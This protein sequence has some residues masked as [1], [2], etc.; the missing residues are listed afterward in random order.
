MNKSLCA[1]IFLVLLVWSPLCFGLK[2]V[3]AKK[4]KTKLPNDPTVWCSTCISFMVQ[5]INQLLNIIANIGVLGSCAELCGYLPNKL[6][7]AVCNVL[8]DVVGIEGFIDL[9]EIA[10]PD[11]VWLC[12]ELDMCT[13]RDSARAKIL[14][15]GVVPKSAPQ[16]TTFNL[17]VKYQV[18]NLTGT[19][20]VGFDV[21]DP[22][23]FIFGDGI[24]IE[25]QTPG[26]YGYQ[27]QLDTDPTEDEPFFPGR[28][29]VTIAVCEGTCG[30]SHSHSFIMDTKDTFFTITGSKK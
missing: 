12:M 11:P 13:S 18:L 8:C 27:M 17:I 22:S 30:S 21:I 4:D 16:G 14:S 15:V 7:Q 19:G 23:G 9:V 28:Y 24:L 29:N 2:Q 3:P 6:E 5:A 25:N 1:V 20:E 10:D 26:P